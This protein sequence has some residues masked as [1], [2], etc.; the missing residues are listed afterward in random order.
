[1]GRCTISG[2]AWRLHEGGLNATTS[3]GGGRGP[4]HREMGQSSQAVT[5]GMMEALRAPTQYRRVYVLLLIHSPRKESAAT[6]RPSQGG[7]HASASPYLFSCYESAPPLLLEERTV[8]PVAHSHSHSH[9]HSIS[10]RAGA[11]G[12]G[13]RKKKMSAYCVGRKGKE[14]E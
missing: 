8:L 10:T 13:A 5:A 2:V 11:C 6:R 3:K 1:V 7:G 12:G 4:T 14:D 9:S